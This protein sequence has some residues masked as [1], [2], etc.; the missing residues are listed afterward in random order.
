M[1][2]LK[3]ILGA[4]LMLV[5]LAVGAGFLLPSSVHVERDLLMDAEPADIFALI[6]DFNAW[7]A[8]S[9][10]AQLDP[11]ATMQITG[12]GLNQTMT[13]SSE[14]PQ[15]GQ[16]SQVIVSLAAPNLL[17]THLDFGSQ[18]MA[19]ATF[20]LVSEDGK[21]RVVWSLD[22]DMREGLPLWQQ[23]ISTY[24]GFAMDA[25]LGPEYETGLQNLKG[26]VES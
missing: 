8:W 14:N 25:M 23:P 3:K 16:G 2:L 4:F 21:T 20:N 9:P 22:T 15:V 24:F 7:D 5:V 11:D 6:S 13:W 17:K 10:W 1:S 18:G 19:D 12:Q 26:L